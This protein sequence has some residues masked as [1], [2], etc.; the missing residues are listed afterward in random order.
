M[1]DPQ[2]WNAGHC[3]VCEGTQVCRGLGRIFSGKWFICV[4]IVIRE[5]TWLPPASLELLRGTKMPGAPILWK[6]LTNPDWEI[7][8]IF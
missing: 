3:R 8:T 7:C 1:F 4:L 6:K 5:G 2:L